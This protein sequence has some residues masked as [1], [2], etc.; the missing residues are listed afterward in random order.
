[1]PTMGWSETPGERGSTRK[2]ERPS[3]AR[4][5]TSTASATCAQGTKRL[6]PVSVQ[7]SPRGAAVA[8]VDAGSQSS[9]SSTSAADRRA[10]PEATA[11]SHLSF[12]AA[13]P[14]STRPRPPS[15]TLAKYGPG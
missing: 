6:T 9:E 13:L 12:W 8:P 15:A 5:G 14:P 3:G 11:G 4:A 2:S 1:M 7:P 10:V